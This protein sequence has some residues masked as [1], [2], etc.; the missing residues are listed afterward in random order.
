[1]QLIKHSKKCNT[2]K[3]YVQGLQGLKHTA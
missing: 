3:E 2:T 1:M